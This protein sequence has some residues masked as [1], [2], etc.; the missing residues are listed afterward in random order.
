MKRLVLGILFVGLITA[1]GLAAEPHVFMGIHWITGE[2]VRGTGVPLT[3]PL[4][5][6]DAVFYISGSDPLSDGLRLVATTS[7]EGKFVF[8]P[9]YNRDIPVTLEAD[10]YSAAV[11]RGLDD[12]GA[13]PETITLDPAGHNYVRLTLEEGAGPG[14]NELLDTGWI[15]NTTIVREGNDI[16]LS[17]DYDPTRGPTDVMIYAL[18]GPAAEFVADPVR[19]LPVDS[20]AISAGT[21]TYVHTGAAYDGNNIYYRVVPATLISGTT[22]LSDENNSITA[23]KVETKTSDGGGYVFVALPFQEDRM[24]LASVISDQISAVGSMFLWWD[25]AKY[26]TSTFSSGIWTQDHDL[27]IGEGFLIYTDPG[28]AEETIALTGRFGTLALPVVRPITAGYNLIAFPYPM[29]KYAA[30]IGITAPS[31]GDMVQKWDK[32]AQSLSVST[33]SGGW[34]DLDITRFELAESKF[35]YTDSEFSW[36]IVFP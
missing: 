18:S 22:V 16:R 36:T 26:G 29:V 6:R 12:Y 19:F 4:D 30:D 34:S 35:Y 13:D 11:I 20:R 15:R 24:S 21:T 25:G 5:G 7:N 23:G 27:Q 31:A 1:S 2:V 8:N 14:S 17:W 28:V 9:F 10:L 32:T 3:V 33:Y